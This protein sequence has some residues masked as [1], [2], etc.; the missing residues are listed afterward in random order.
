MN[1][2][3]SGV[4]SDGTYEYRDG[5]QTKMRGT[6]SQEYEIYCSFTDDNPPKSYEEYLNS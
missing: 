6:N 5:Y 3:K 4:N 2:I 1:D